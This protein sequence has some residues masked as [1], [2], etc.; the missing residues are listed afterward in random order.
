MVWKMLTMKRE[1]IIRPTCELNC[2]SKTRLLYLYE[3]AKTYVP[4]EVQGIRRRNARKDAGVN[5]T[6]RTHPH[7]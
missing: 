6:T 2:R 5:G 4:L 3:Y 1:S 7:G